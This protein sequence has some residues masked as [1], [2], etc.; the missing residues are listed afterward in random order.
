V[1]AARRRR[2]ILVGYYEEGKFYYAGK[3]RAGFTPATRRE[4]WQR[5]DGSQIAKCPK[6]G[7]LKNGLSGNT[8]REAHV[9]PLLW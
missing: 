1:V 6:L 5:I 3:V 4:V 2:C 8:C 9:E 7:I